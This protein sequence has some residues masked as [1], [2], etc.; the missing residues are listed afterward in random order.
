MRSEYAANPRSL[1]PSGWSTNYDLTGEAILARK[2]PKVGVYR[3]ADGNPN[4]FKDP[5]DVQTNAFRHPYPGESG[6]RNILRRPGYFGID[7]GLAKQWSITEQ[8]KLKF[9]W[10]VCHVTNS[11]RFDAANSTNA[12]DLSSSGFG[13]YQ[14]GAYQAPRDAI[15]PA[16]QLLKLLP[17]R[18]R[19]SL[20][21]S[22]LDFETFPRQGRHFDPHWRV[23]SRCWRTWTQHDLQSS[24]G[25]A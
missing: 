18:R 1:T 8:Q 10:E 25:R 6:E 14:F 12:F 13:V 4:M 24:T 3:D 5:L 7:T 21:P 22:L 23:G 16:L 19:S 2:T 9:S 20:L 17:G 15:F 11:V